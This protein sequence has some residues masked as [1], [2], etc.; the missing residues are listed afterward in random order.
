MCLALHSIPLN[1]LLVRG[2]LVTHPW[3][4]QSAFY[5]YIFTVGWRSPF[6]QFSQ[7]N[8]R[9]K[10]LERWSWWANT[11]CLQHSSC[12]FLLISL[13]K[14]EAMCES[15]GLSSKAFSYARKWFLIK[16]VELR[17]ISTYSWPLSCFSCTQLWC[18]YLQTHVVLISTQ[19]QS[20]SFIYYSWHVVQT[21]LYPL[22]ICCV[23]PVFCVHFWFF[24]TSSADSLPLKSK[25]VSSTCR[26]VQT[27]LVA[28]S[29]EILWCS[30]V[31]MTCVSDQ[32]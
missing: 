19:K 18:G 24:F 30:C 20:Q 25:C 27:V 31:K 15:S 4:K 29:L 8:C 21:R 12:S 2:K 6:D 22:C 11:T 3:F 16:V 17:W 13:E 10:I 5:I 1:S 7:I 9:L 14:H 28:Y 23:M 32:H 26:K